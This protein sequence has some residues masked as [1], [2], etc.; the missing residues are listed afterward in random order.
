MWEKCQKKTAL[1]TL[2]DNQNHLILSIKMISQLVSLEY[3]ELLVSLLNDVDDYYI[4]HTLY[5]LCLDGS[6]YAFSCLDLQEKETP[7]QDLGDL[8]SPYIH[9]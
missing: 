3:K 8:L 6:S 2:K 5:T 7:I 9:I 4:K 1:K